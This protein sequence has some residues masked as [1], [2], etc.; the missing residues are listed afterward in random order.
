MDNDLQLVVANTEMVA[1]SG[2]VIGV[3][4]VGI[5]RESADGKCTVFFISAWR[6][7]IFECSGVTPFDFQETGDLKQKKI[8]NVCHKLKNSEEFARNQN[9]V[10][11]RIIRRPTCSSCRVHMEGKN[12]T[13]SEKKKWE[14]IKPKMT[15]FECPICSKRTI[16]GVTSK[17]VLEH[18]HMTGNVRDWVCD[19]C[20]TGLGRFKDD[21]ALLERAIDFLDGK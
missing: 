8:C 21:K 16:A 17:V 14:S 12:I 11:N 4:D 18:D 9:G 1:D 15:P 5:L 20:N 3:D 6:E 2:D 10:N 19:S 13:S 7:N